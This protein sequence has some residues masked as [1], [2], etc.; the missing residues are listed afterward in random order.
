MK[1]KNWVKKHYPEHLDEIYRILTPDGVGEMRN[2][3]YTRL[4]RLLNNNYHGYKKGTLFLWKRSKNYTD[5]YDEEGRPTF[6]DIKWDGTFDEHC[7]FKCKD[8]VTFSGFHSVYLTGDNWEEVVKLKGKMS[9]KQNNE[10]KKMEKQ[11][12]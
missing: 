11:N 6:G 2:G 12:A 1:D 10:N 4:G 8:G 5:S 9:K 7:L 3:E